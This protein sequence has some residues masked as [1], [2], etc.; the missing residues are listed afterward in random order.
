M[1]LARVGEGEDF[2]Q[3]LEAGTDSSNG[4][5]S[6]ATHWVLKQRTIE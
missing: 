3:Q 5:A 2:L 4:Y 6:N 1:M